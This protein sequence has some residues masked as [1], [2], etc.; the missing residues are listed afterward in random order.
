P[1]D[2]IAALKESSTE[3]LRDMERMT[4]LVCT[5]NGNVIG[6]ARYRILESGDA[7]IAYISRVCVLPEE[8][9]T[10]AGSQLLLEIERQCRAKKVDML[11]L[12]TPAKMEKLVRFY[13]RNGYYIN[14]TKSDRGYARG[15]FLK[16]LTDKQCSLSPLDEL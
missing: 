14:G 15:L 2:G 13:Y 11:A 8:Q 3:I 16:E 12:H 7:K 9:R 10:G 4:V 5:K 1:P 6:T